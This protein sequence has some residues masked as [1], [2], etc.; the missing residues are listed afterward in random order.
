MWGKQAAHAEIN[1]EWPSQEL[2]DQMPAE[3]SLK[4]VLFASFLGTSVGT[5]SF[6]QCTL[7]NG[8][9]SP[10]FSNTETKEQCMPKVIHFD[11]GKKVR[12]VQAGDN[13]CG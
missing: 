13:G 9:T 4:S 5:I 6:T 10:L 12:R 2:L 8:D 7:S 11:D 1:F 3:V